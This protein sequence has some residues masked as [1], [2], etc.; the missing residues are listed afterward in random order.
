MLW[1]YHTDITVYCIYRD[2]SIVCVRYIYIV[3]TVVVNNHATKYHYAR[4]CQ[5]YIFVQ[6]WPVFLLVV[7]STMYCLHAWPA[8][9][10]IHMSAKAHPPAPGSPCHR[11]LGTKTWRTVGRGTAAVHIACEPTCSWMHA[12]NLSRLDSTCDRSIP[13][14]LT[15]LPYAMIWHPSHAEKLP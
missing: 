10:C 7:L 2:Y 9:R 15:S 4:C 11:C 3:N 6:Q 8:L 1:L 13:A 12:S 5:C 14:S